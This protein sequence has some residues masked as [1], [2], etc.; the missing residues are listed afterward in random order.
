[1]DRAGIATAVKHFPGLG[2]VRGNTDLVTK[3]VDSTTTRHDQDL[4][5]FR[6]AVKSEVDMVM[7]SSA[8][9][10]KID[11][12]RRAAYSSTVIKGMIRSDLDFAGVVISDDLAAPGA[13]DLPA[14]TRAL[15][16]LRAG[17][18]LVIVGDPTQVTAMTDA[19]EDEAAEDADLR[20]AV[21]ESA[22]RVLVMKATRDL[23]DC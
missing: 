15:R 10:T 16:F 12:D 17:G 20:A 4:A 19:V 9:Y 7:L 11:P 18:D 3:V 21:A 2:H 8:Y 22:R 1:M 5:G 6:A 13:E 14:G 23:A